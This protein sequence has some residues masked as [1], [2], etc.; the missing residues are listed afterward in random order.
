[1]IR[2]SQLRR[3]HDNTLEGAS[4][5]SSECRGLYD[6]AVDCRDI[7]DY[8]GDAKSNPASHNHSNAERSRTNGYEQ[9]ARHDSNGALTRNH[10]NQQDT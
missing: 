2:L 3:H 5:F 9:G 7:F 4:Q 6:K 8:F 10:G 1:M